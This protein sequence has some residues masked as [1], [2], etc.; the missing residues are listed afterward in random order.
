MERVA[1]CIAEHTDEERHTGRGKEGTKERE[2]ERERAKQYGH[3]V[4]HNEVRGTV[5]R[6]GERNKRIRDFCLPAQCAALITHSSRADWC[7]AILN[8]C[9]TSQS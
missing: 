9:S 4:V 7:R 2:R 5:A 3:V 1:R 6:R 8:P